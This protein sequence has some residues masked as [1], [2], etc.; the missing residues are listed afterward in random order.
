MI[1][2]VCVALLLA[3]LFWPSA[4]VSQKEKLRVVGDVDNDGRDEELVLVEKRGYYG[5]DLPFWEEE[6]IDDFGNHLFVYKTET[7]E[8]Q[9]QWGSSTISHEIYD[10][11]IVDVD[12]DG[13]IDLAVR[14]EI[15]D[16]VME[17]NDFG[18]KEK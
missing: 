13:L 1:A 12:N 2:A 15:G 4:G 11:Q 18:F 9:L 5:P 17:W 3:W 14:S 7:N 6:N 16:Y 10:M 8:R